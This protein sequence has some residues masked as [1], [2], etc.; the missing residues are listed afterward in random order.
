MTAFN[1]PTLGRK[2]SDPPSDG[3]T[4]ITFSSHTNHLLVSS[5]DSTVRLYDPSENVLK[6]KFTHGGSV[7]DC[8]FDEDSSGFFSASL[9]NTVRKFDFTS[10]KEDVLGKHEA[11]V[12]CVE[13]SNASGQLIS[14]SWDKTVKCWDPRAASGKEHTLVGTH[15]QPERVYSVSLVGNRLVVATAGRHV[16]VYDLRNM[17]KPEQQRESPLK[18]Q[19][20]SVR[21]YPNGTGF[22]VSSVEG[23]VAMEF[24]DITEAGQAKSYGTFASGGCDGYVNVWD[25]NNKKRLYQYSK[26]PTSIAA[27]AFSRDGCMLAVA[28]SYT[29]EEGKK[30]YDPT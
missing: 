19:T 24:F 15:L 8:C 29:Y 10:G 11:P 23:R 6:V 27:L 13:H 12:R 14:G 1:L 16:N 25:G 26:Y 7:L 17:S 30:Q 4:N 3:I 28:S 9:D 20:R 5:W 21:C 18:Y 22:A 2:L